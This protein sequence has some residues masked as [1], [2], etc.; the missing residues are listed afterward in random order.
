MLDHDF[1]LPVQYVR[2]IAEQVRSSGAEVPR[3]LS[4]S[5]LSEA[6]LEDASLQL[7]Y[8]VLRQLVLD[9]LAV[10]RE[11]ALG[12]LVGERLVASAHGFVGYAA[13]S[14]ATIGEALDV[15]TRF[16][17]LRTTLFTI[18]LERRP[19]EV[20]V[21]FDETAPLGDIRRPVLEASVLS[22]KNTLDSASMGACRISHVAFPWAAPGYQALARALL[23]CEVRYG[24]A[25]AGLSL[26]P[27]LLDVRL[28]QADPAAFQ[29]AAQICQRELDKLAANESTAARVRRLLLA[30]QTGFPS[31]QTTARLLHV[32][33]RTL[34]RRLVA[35]GT[36]YRA[37][38]EDVRR[39]LA[40]DH[41]RS[42]RFSVDEIAY[43][44][45]YADTANFRRA[46]KRWEA[47]PPS[48]YRARHERGRGRAP[49]D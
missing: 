15:L 46:F 5:Q 48:E 27:E 41:L 12:L 36:S 21:R 37:L 33:P 29:E 14:S 19:R 18:S 4:L 16:A 2:Y 25:W 13:V 49:A 34:H 24:Q 30:R 28:R 23:G 45:G 3:W 31:L 39:T 20:R 11:P 47:V 7:S 38:L 22:V 35:E 8:P 43:R 1:T 17:G 6:S 42:R 26:A 32:T 40:V 10:S 44:L 9:A